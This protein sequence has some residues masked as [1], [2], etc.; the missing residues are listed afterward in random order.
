MIRRPPRSTLFPYATLFRSLSATSHTVALTDV[1]ANCT[2][3][4]G[5]S[6]TVTVTAGQ[7]TTEPFSISCVATT[8]SLTVSTTTTGPEQ[9]SGYTVSVTGGGRPNLGATSSGTLT[10]LVTGSPTPTPRRAPA[11]STA[12]G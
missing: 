10:G 2:A 5:A 12:S 9:P 3:S 11:H 8:G 1:P 7:T 6:H 4:G